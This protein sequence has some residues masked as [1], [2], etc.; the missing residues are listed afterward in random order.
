MTFEPFAA[1]T[2]KRLLRQPVGR[3]VKISAVVGS[4]IRD[5]PGRLRVMTTKNLV[6]CLVAAVASVAFD[7]RIVAAQTSSTVHVVTSETAV[8]SRPATRSEV[9]RVVPPDTAL[10]IIGRE[11]D[12]DWVVLPPD[13]NGTRHSGWIQTRGLTP[14][15]K[16]QLKQEREDAQR[17]KELQAQ[18]KQE[19][20]LR[21]KE[22]QA[23]L[24]QEQAE[25]VK[26]EQAQM[27]EERRVE[28]AKREV[29]KARREYEKVASRGAAP[30][31]SSSDESNPLK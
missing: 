23:R 25:K 8:L 12:W 19:E 11:G 16:L 28:K 13:V 27:E 4:T 3:I 30:A 18:L 14:E 22:D 31:S 29:E 15:K 20:A 21:L 5:D 24:K 7:G 26:Q 1:D 6:A 17:L 9:V 10:E 2:P